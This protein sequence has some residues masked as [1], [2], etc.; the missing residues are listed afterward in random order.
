MH[1]DYR[2]HLLKLLAHAGQSLT[3]TTAILREPIS[4]HDRQTNEALYALM[5]DTR[6]NIERKLKAEEQVDSLKLN[7]S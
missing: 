5:V 2:T 6:A 4:D 3:E 1:S 7:T